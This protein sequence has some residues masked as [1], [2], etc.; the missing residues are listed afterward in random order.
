MATALQLVQQATGEMGLGVPTFVVGNAASDVIQQLALLN[1]VGYE[2]QRKFDWQYLAKEYRFTTAFSQPTGTTT[3]GSAVVTGLSSTAGLA[4]N[5]WSVTGTGIPTDTTI[6]S[7]D[8]GTQITLSQAATAS[9]A[10]TL[11]CAK[12]KYAL[13]A[14]Y[15]RLVDNTEWDK[16]KRWQMLGPET[17][18]QWQWLKSGYIAT[19][20]RVRFRVMG[21]TLQVWPPL[22]A[23]EYLGFEYLSN[24]WAFDTSGNGKGS[25]TADSDTCAF[26]DRLMVLGLKLKYF[27]IKGFDTTAFAR[28]FND[29]LNLAKANDHGSPILSLA[30]QLADVLID[31][32]QIPDTGFGT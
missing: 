3:S 12:I 13:P 14:D 5:T 23:A 1:A 28:D 20:P 11:T 21:N 24:Y 15:D 31:Q 32:T 22:S 17:A 26:P 16:S 9:G 6:A 27:E 4:A 30:P 25:F 8:S 29:E 18:Q 2:L 7:V 10:V 19:G